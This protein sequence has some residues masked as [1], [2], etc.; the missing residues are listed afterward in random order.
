MA[1]IKKRSVDTASQAM[2]K[3]AESEGLETLW[4]RFEGMQP[5]CGFGRLGICCTTC[6]M[7][8]CRI[9]PFGEGPDTGICGANADTIVA[10]NLLKKIAAGTAAH[11]DHGRN[12]AQTLLAVAEGKVHDNGIADEKKL[13]RIAAI[14][15][16]STEGK[17]KEELA[18]EVAQYALSDFGQ[19]EG[20]I[21]FTS[22][23]PAIW[24]RSWVIRGVLQ[25]TTPANPRNLP[26][27]M[28]SFRGR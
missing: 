2:L 26:E 13:Q 17:K 21:K 28:A 4:D 27:M 11:S 1:D 6:D 8:P 5:Q 25:P 9:D 23:A 12:V 15:G 24:D 18:K 14:Y 19:Q 10:R 22:R 16:I 7:G 20:E 3:K